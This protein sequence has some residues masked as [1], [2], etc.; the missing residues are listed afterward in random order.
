MIKSLITFLRTI[1]KTCFYYTKI[2]GWRMTIFVE[3]Y[4]GPWPFDQS[5]QEKPLN[6]LHLT[7]LQPQLGSR[8]R[9]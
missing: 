3:H 2:N 6:A 9:A 8:P 4:Q 5:L 7:P 1:P